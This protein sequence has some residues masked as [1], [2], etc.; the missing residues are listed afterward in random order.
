M[1]PLL[2]ADLFCGAGGTSTGLLRA[3]SRLGRTVDLLAIN[4]WAEAVATHSLNYPTVRHLQEDLGAVDPRK[5]VP[6]GR[7]DI[8]VASPECTSHSYSRG[9]RPISEQSRA[10]AWHPLRWADQLKVDGIL[11]ENVP[12]FRDWGPTDRRG[13]PIKSRRGQ[14]Y[15]QYLL[16]LES[17]GYTVDTRIL[18]AADFGAATTRRRLFIMA[19]K[20]RRAVSWPDPT[21]AQGALTGLR[22]WRAAREIIDWSVPGESI[23]TRKRPLSPSTR[24]R[25]LMGLKK[26]GSPSLEPWLVVLRKHMNSRP[27]SDP[28]PTVAAGGQHIGLAEPFLVSTNHGDNAQGSGRGNG[29][30]IRSV[31]DPLR[32]VTGTRGEAL[33]QP[34]L[35]GSGGAWDS[36]P[37]SLDAPLRAIMSRQSKA[38][39]EPFL[40]PH[41]TFKNMTVDSLDDPIRTITA[42]SSDFGLV[43]PVVTDGKTE[44]PVGQPFLVPFFGE[45]QGQKP[46]THSI[47]VPLPA[48]TSHGAGG[49]AAPFLVKYNRTGGP[50]SVEQPLD[51]LTTK[52][53]YGLVTTAGLKIADGLYL[54]IRFRMLKAHELA[55]GMGFPATYRFVGNVEEQV[56]QIG[57]AVEC[58]QAEALCLALL[59]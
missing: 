54:D 52:D 21:H 7:L 20:G 59:A 34:F 46:R 19:L 26:F 4:H 36:R 42:C 48:V 32:T 27:L 16:M 2:G 37:Q 8:L 31:D 55:A 25:I 44:E 40:V 38:L 49:V 33:I 58:N 15:Q 17:M 39:V 12:Q 35:I 47:D 43:E 51:T 56:R 13:H 23:F 1:R 29:G 3:A 50:R 45:R 9:A 57:N 28:L 24:E 6:G 5:A 14:T 18:N 11:I 41:R 22:P 30:R 53:R 10:S